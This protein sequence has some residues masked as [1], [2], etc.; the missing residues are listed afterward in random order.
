MNDQEAL[1]CAE[2]WYLQPYHAVTHGHITLDGKGQELGDAPVL[3]VDLLPERGRR[4]S[5][6]WSI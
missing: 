6:C 3:G 5:L 2:T 1:T 4:W